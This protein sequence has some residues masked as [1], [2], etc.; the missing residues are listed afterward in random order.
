MED[1]VD[2]LLRAASQH[3]EE[4]QFVVE[5]S[6]QVTKPVTRSQIKTSRFSV[7]VSDKE[8]QQKV[9]EAVPEKTRQKT[10]WAHSLRMTW[11][12]HRIKIAQTPDECPPKLVEMK[13]A[14]LSKWLCKFI[15]EIRHND[16]K[17]Y[18]GT[19]LHQIL[20]GI[21]R[22]LREETDLLLIFS[23][24]LSFGVRRVC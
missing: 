13:K 17:P 9:L 1:E 14:D 24:I 16:G 11:R 2:A 21:Q 4:Q 12:L 22:H 10:K 5:D 8:L 7:P 20:C 23:L 6:R 3:Y 18:T 15:V 19:T